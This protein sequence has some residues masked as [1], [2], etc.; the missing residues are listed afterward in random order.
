[1]NIQDLNLTEEYESNGIG[2]FVSQ[3]LL[4]ADLNN[5]M[6]GFFD[7][8]MRDFNG[9]WTSQSD[10][11]TD[12]S[13][14]QLIAI[15]GQ[16]LAVYAALKQR[17]DDPVGCVSSPPGSDDYP[18]QMT[19]KGHVVGVGKPVERV[20]PVMCFARDGRRRTDERAL[21]RFGV[22]Y[23]TRELE[24]Q[25][26]ARNLWPDK[27]VKTTLKMLSIE[28]FVVKADRT[29]LH[30]GR[31]KTEE[32]VGW[33]VVGDRLTLPAK[34][35][36]AALQT[37]LRKAASDPFDTSIVTITNS[38]GIVSLAIVTPFGDDGDG[39]ALVL[40]E[41]RHSDHQALKEHF[42]RAYGLTNSEYQIA[43]GVLNG[44]GLA[45]VA[46]ATNLSLSTVRSYMK[47][48]FAKT[49]THRQSELIALYY[50]SILP[51]GDSVKF[52]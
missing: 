4:L 47:Q 30:D 6:F 34:R 22:T 26:L 2:D 19:V 31:I 12:D 1:M 36:L 51:I 44:K 33:V 20:F 42:F 17:K 29:I 9:T 18:I 38:A 37:A 49:D 24:R 43:T 7:A 16:R 5:V 41:N 45:D 3:F 11:C 50:R 32:D 25:M 35:E 10:D 14:H 15:A 52:G 39:L 48:V 23:L 27:L 8:D 28:F 40:F 13:C 46:A 21:V